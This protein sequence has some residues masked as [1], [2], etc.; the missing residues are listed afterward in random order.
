M[1]AAETPSDARPAAEEGQKLTPEQ[2]QARIKELRDK[3]HTLAPDQRDAL[4]AEQANL[5]NLVVEWGRNYTEMLPFTINANQNDPSQLTVI[6]TA[7][8]APDRASLPGAWRT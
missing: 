3:F 1:P 4:L 8:A 6:E 7:H 2:R 5:E